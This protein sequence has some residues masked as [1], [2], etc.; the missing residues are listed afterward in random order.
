MYKTTL[1]LVTLLL[2]ITSCSED[3][4]ADRWVSDDYSGSFLCVISGIT[5]IY[6][7]VSVTAD[8]DEIS[9][10]FK[11]TSE[12]LIGTIDTFDQV[13]MQDYTFVF[14][15][16]S[17]IELINGVGQFEINTNNAAMVETEFLLISYQVE[18]QA[19]EICQFAL[20][21]L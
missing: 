7:Q 1:L 17:T 4:P 16:G 10:N 8:G 9:V 5:E 11:D 12:P 19:D 13:E 3:S 20:G 21:Q 2:S 18:G 6:G 14:D 15:D